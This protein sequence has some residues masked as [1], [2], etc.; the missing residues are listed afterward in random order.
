MV[1]SARPRSRSLLKSEI[2]ETTTEN[3]RYFSQPD[4][5]IGWDSSRNCYY[6]GYDLYLFTDV[7]R[8]L[9]IFPLYGPASKHDSFAC[10]DTW[11]TMKPFMPYAKVNSIILDS[12]HDAM[13]YYKY[14]TQQ[15]VTPYID[16]NKRALKPELRDGFSFDDNHH[17]ICPCGKKM[18][19]DGTGYKRMRTKYVCP[20][21]TKLSTMTVSTCD[22]QPTDRLRGCIMYL[23]HEENPR[24]FTVPARDSQQWKTMYNKRSSSER[25]NKRIK[26]DFKLEDGKHRSSQMWYFRLYCIM[27]CQHLN[28]WSLPMGS[29][30]WM[31]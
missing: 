25:C 7:N 1:T 28:A 13:C 18:W 27:M 19:R 11:F 9:P 23:S 14:F 2:S 29:E 22:N 16:L 6:S 17:I 24:Y 12:A 5:D 4:C 3:D 31:N 8:D 10:L 20:L 21:Q 26:I 30:P 15:H